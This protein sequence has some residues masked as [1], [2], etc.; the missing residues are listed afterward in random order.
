MIN[1]SVKSKFLGLDTTLA[2]LWLLG[3]NNSSHSLQLTSYSVLL[4]RNVSAFSYLH[5][6]RDK[7]IKYDM[8]IYV[9]SVFSDRKANRKVLH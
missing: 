1:P 8:H 7:Q 6:F 2:V 3:H 9:Y 5:E 4:D